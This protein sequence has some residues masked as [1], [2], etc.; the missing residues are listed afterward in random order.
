MGKQVGGTAAGFGVRRA[1][2]R[3]S[4]YAGTS[5]NTAP[6]RVLTAG[7]QARG[8]AIGGNAKCALPPNTGIGVEGTRR[9]VGD[10]SGRRMTND[11]VVRMLEPAERK[12]DMTCMAIQAAIGSKEYQLKQ[13][14]TESLPL[15]AADLVAPARRTL[16]NTCLEHNRCVLFHDENPCFRIKSTVKDRGG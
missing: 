4:T 6:D 14:F 2:E 16:T 8:A 3:P 7:A 12:A 10:A 1:A 11:F 5:G 9:K 15:R 13:I